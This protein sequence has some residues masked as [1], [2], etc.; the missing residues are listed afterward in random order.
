M[1]RKSKAIVESVGEAQASLNYRYIEKR[2]PKE[3]ALA[4]DMLAALTPF[5]ALCLQLW[6][7]QFKR[8]LN[9]L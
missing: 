1:G 9:R 6:V 4:L 8:L 7:Q 2:K 3:A 5:M